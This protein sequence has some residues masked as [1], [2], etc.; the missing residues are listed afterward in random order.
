VERRRGDRTSARRFLNL[1]L[2]TAE[3]LGHVYWTVM[4]R[5]GLALHH[6]EGPAPADWEKA[7][8][9]ADEAVAQAREATL[10]HGVI[11]GQSR[12]GWALWRLGRLD[13]ARQRSEDAAHTLQEQRIVE[14]SEEEVY[15]TH[16]R[17][18]AAL[19]ES[20]AEEAAR[21]L[22]L[23]ARGLQEKA[24]RIKDPARRTS[25]LGVPLHREILALAGGATGPT[26]AGEETPSPP[27]S[28]ASPAR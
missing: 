20:H 21:Y 1:A 18:L 25:F 23:A 15:F 12:A 6:V 13:E 14:C 2:D 11:Q 26:S 17:V 9:V 3:Q 4:A 5:L 28:R 19:G 8:K 10:V 24:A 16:H 27:P 22:E 7:L